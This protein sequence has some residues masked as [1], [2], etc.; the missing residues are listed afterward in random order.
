M[1]RADLNINSAPFIEE[2]YE[3][4]KKDSSSVTEEWQEYFARVQ[5]EA[6]TSKG[7]STGG[8]SY[9]VSGNGS[10]AA[11][12]QASVGRLIHA[13]REVGH[14]YAN[15]NPL[16]SYLMPELKYLI[17]TIEGP[18]GSLSLQDFGLSED[19][20][21]K[22]FDAGTNMNPPRGTL[23]EILTA[24]KNIYCSSMGAEILHIQNKTMRRWLI[25]K[26]EQNNN[27]PDWTKEQKQ[28]FAK[29]LIKAEEFE[30][31]IHGHY[32]GQKRFSLEGGE[33]LI[34]ALHFLLDR[35]AA[36]TGIQE[37]VMGMAHRGRLNVL[38][39]VLGKPSLEIFSTFEENYKAHKYGGSGDVKYHIGFSIDH[40]HDDGSTIHVSLVANPSHLEAVDPVV[41]G[42][43]RGVQRRRGDVH[44]KKVI[45]VLIH[46]D[47]AFTGQG[48]V[49]E[50]FNL[51]Q[52]RGYKTGGTIHIIV[53]N[54]IGFTTA[55][56]D[57]R[58]TFF[59]TDIAKSM[60][61]PVLHVNGNDPEQVV[62]A[63]DLALRFRHKFGYDVVVDIVCY[64]KYGHNEA[65]EPA[66]THPI[67]YNRIK[68][69]P[70]VAQVY[71]EKLEKEGSFSKEEEQSFRSEY[72]SSLEADMEQSRKDPIEF[73]ADAFQYGE[74][75]GI[76]REYDH[77]PVNT[78]VP[79]ETLKSIGEKL[80]YVP[81]E[82]HINP[83]LRKIIEVRGAMY[84]D[85]Q[86]I[87]WSSAEALCFGSLLIENIPIRLSGEDSARGTFSQ[88]HAVWWNVATSK[89]MPYTPLNHLSD[90]QARFSVYDSP[91]SEYSVLGFEYGNAMTQP[92]MLNM[93]EAQFGDFVNG[94]QVI[95][96]N[97]IA[98]GESK[99]GRGNGLVML[100]PHAYEGQGP[101]HSSGHMERFLQLCAEDNMQVC[102]L[103]TP[104]QY[105]HVL[106]RQLKRT[107][108]KP[109]II[110][111]PKSLLRN[112]RCVSAIAE[113][114]EGGFHEVLDDP[115]DNHESE[116]VVLCTGKVF[117]DYL[118]RREKSDHK[119]AVV[120]LEQL[121]PFP[122]EQL[123][124][125]LAGYK[126]AKQ[127]IWL[128]EEPRNRGAWTFI[129]DRIGRC[130]G[131]APIRY[132]G[133]AASASPAT[134][135]HKQHAEE[136]D[137]F[138]S[139]IFGPVPAESVHH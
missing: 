26:L 59:P 57:A 107:F 129:S 35:A 104:A 62:R 64:R 72:R 138:L 51:S 29:D 52:L 66:F 63:M 43:A 39:N 49:A 33:V 34:P 93:W 89:P 73:A 53:N 84:N 127:F 50:T 121:Y 61:M 118:E 8:S 65:D 9:R 1:F 12:K 119:T 82:M 24:L 56:R 76:T 135:S 38:T 41:E 117:Y 19:D 45:P 10:A 16:G 86:G 27:T 2:L 58:S 103:T 130:I 102:N 23:R 124:A 105:F 75:A 46:G 31:F 98:A 21:D 95:I 131:D 91:L 101:E 6:I 30:H 68:N 20:L 85:G 28:Q 78:T 134:G 47:S 133:R 122:Q 108:R 37:I 69:S 90:T 67:M 55:S 94:A 44:R 88:R 25:E 87:D 14:L 111:T 125:V 60:P 114:S 54:Q 137:Q 126:K 96:D 18:Y 11:S 128:Q 74:W 71:C 106:R 92:H 83:K 99:W 48:V 70:S 15:T 13:Y 4:W 109:L 116:T 115:E 132:V 81:E 7:L 136:M 139:E 17:K 77:A 80:C 36:R 40:V 120:R 42:K 123:N 110:M 113:L 100:L 3:S 22:V 112:K 97:F 5:T 32:I 79:A